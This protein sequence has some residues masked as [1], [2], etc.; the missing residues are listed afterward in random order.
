MVRYRRN[1]VPG[2]TYF[3]SVTLADRSATMLTDR[4]EHLRSA[5]EYARTRHVFEIVAIVIL[6][7]H[8]HCVWTLPTNDADYATRW[9]LIKSAFTR[10]LA[11]GA[12]A[13]P[14]GERRVWQ[15]R[16]WEHTIANDADLQRHVDYIHF[17]PVKHGYVERPVDW[18]SSSFH[19]YV[20]RGQLPPDWA[21]DVGGVAAEF[22][23]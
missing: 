1:L 20:R 19:R 12:R 17:N 6:P 18:P 9:R 16:F 2:G 14:K 5:F 15:R 10:A 22:G 3:F 13:T 7:D 8:L 11:P 4:I 21:S 23:E